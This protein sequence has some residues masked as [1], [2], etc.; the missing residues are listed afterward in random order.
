MT[1]F[2][3]LAC[4][5]LLGAALLAAPAKAELDLD[6]AAVSRLDN[7]LTI[8]LLEEHSLPLVSVQVIYRSGSRDETA[9]KTGLA[10]FLEHLA[11]R[12]SEH[13]PRGAATDAI[14]DAGGEWHGYTWLDQTSYFATVPAG[15]LDLL[16]RIEADRMARVTIDP[17]SIEAERGA[18]LTEMHGYENDPG[19]VLFDAVAAAALQS[20]PYR[21]NTIGYES[22]VGALTAEDV[23]AFYRTHYAPANAVLAIVGDLTPAA[24]MALVRRHFGVLAGE[25]APPRTAAVEPPQRGERR[26]EVSGPVERQHVELAW[27][28]P[29]ASSPD[30]APFL[31]LQQ[32]LSGGSGVNFYQNDWGTPATEG[33]ALHGA[34]EDLAS[35]MIPT[36]DPY[37]FTVTASIPAGADRAALELEIGARIARVRAETPSPARLASARHALAEQLLFDV[38]TTE[39]AAH[40]LGFFE[41]IGAFDALLDLPRR[42][43]AVSGEDVLRVARAYLAPEQRTVGWLVPGPAI[44]QPGLGAGEPRRAGERAAGEVASGEPAPPPEV[45]RLTNGIALAVQRSALS[46][47]ASVLVVMSHPVEEGSQ[48]ADLVGLGIIV[49]SGRARDLP[50]LIEQARRAAAAARPRPQAPPSENPDT[51]LEQMIARRLPVTPCGEIHP[52]AALVSGAVDPPAAFAALAE[53]FGAPLPETSCTGN[54]IA[55]PRPGET[56]G[57]RI[58]RPL[59]QAALGYAVP[60]PGP[61]TREGLAWGILLYVLTHDYG[62]RLGN[63]AI[64]D[65]GLIYHIASAYRLPGAVTLSI[66]VD[67]ARLDAMEAALRAEL[68]RLAS[69]PPT[70]AEVDAAK[71]HLLGRDLSAAQSN[72]E[73]VQ[74]LARQLV[75]TGALRSHQAFAEGLE[76]IGPAEVAAAAPAFTAGTILRVDVGA[77]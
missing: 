11:F 17:A 6:R 48:P 15:E 37:L 31:V 8:I 59:A 50:A 73:I 65:R 52:I 54:L 3:A 22:D 67:P 55:R 43:A 69:H 75:A 42:V 21:N 38:E 7:G 46:P 76:A 49:R 71:R 47:T 45:R 28:A 10:H 30:L 34:A 60:A 74:R 20:H 12:A 61:A 70:A 58:D 9:G 2:R 16:L 14:Y 4:C 40:Q 41:G 51:R 44:P 23:R 35:W 29:A 25:A 57:E 5:C 63:A 39:D 27:R 77:D 68:A 32:L 13:F 36:A 53:A 24:A 19:S 1:I 72:E 18:V 64:R 26:I 62:G 66:G 56:I 33:S